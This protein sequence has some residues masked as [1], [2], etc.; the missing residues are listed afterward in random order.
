MITLKQ[1]GLVT[2]CFPNSPILP[3]IEHENLKPQIWGI[4]TGENVLNPRRNYWNPV[5]YCIGEAVSPEHSEYRAACLDFIHD[6]ATRLRLIHLPLLS[7]DGVEHNI[8]DTQGYFFEHSFPDFWV[9]YANL[10]DSSFKQVVRDHTKWLIRHEENGGL[11]KDNIDWDFSFRAYVR[12]F[13]ENVCMSETDINS[14]E[15]RYQCSLNAIKFLIRMANHVADG[16]IETLGWDENRNIYYYDYDASK[17][18]GYRVNH[19]YFTQIFS[20]IMLRYTFS[21]HYL[22][23][24]SLAN[25]V[26]YKLSQS[27]RTMA[28]DGYSSYRYDEYSIDGGNGFNED[29]G[30]HADYPPYRFLTIPRSEFGFKK[31]VES[32]SIAQLPGF[33]HYPEIVTLNTFIENKQVT[34]P[35]EQPFDVV[36]EEDDRDR[37]LIDKMNKA[38]IELE[39]V[40]KD[41]LG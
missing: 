10:Y 21:N 14:P 36:E 3:V 27:I 35:S 39:S 8:T 13:F 9:L 4:N 11:W 29:G 37:R 26:I 32:A 33:G 38:L 16:S 41:L 12:R 18:F 40:K 22:R 23:N 15:D 5:M 19:V 30:T 24:K 28:G 2:P 31:I 1:I 17:K 7:D 6:Y 34:I 25:Q 20:E